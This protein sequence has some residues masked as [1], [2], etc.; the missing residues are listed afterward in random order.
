MP[1]NVVRADS[2]P[3][4]KASQGAGTP[5]PTWQTTEDAKGKATTNRIIAVI[6][7]VLA[8]AGEAFAIFWILKQ[9]PVNMV[10]LIGAIVVIGILAVIGSQLWKKAN[11]WDP[12]SKSEPVRFFIQNQLG[13]IIAIIAF[14]PLIYMIFTNKN[15][16]KQQKSIAGV[17]GIVVLLIAGVLG[18]DFN[19]PS[20][21]QYT[22]I[23]ATQVMGT[24]LPQFPNEVAGVVGYTGKDEVFWTKTGTVYHLCSK[25]SDLQRESQD[26]QIYVGSV[27]QAHA[28]GKERLTLKV[29]EE[30]NQCG[31][32]KT[33]L[34][35]AKP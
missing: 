16:D 5:P 29:Q 19:P 3:T 15:M 34:P 30:L 27:A 35:T 24:A 21:E 8:I 31:I 6:L 33:A 26:N 2:K 20:V 17:V 22:M 32:N 23:Q 1:K 14:L 7:W 12:A 4:A 11:D 13:V 28:A 18:I 10:F 25:V 9:T